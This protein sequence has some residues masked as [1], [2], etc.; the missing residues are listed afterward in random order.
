[1]KKLITFIC[2]NLI[3]KALKI[4]DKYKISILTIVLILIT[5][6]CIFGMSF[7]S[8]YHNNLRKYKEKNYNFTVYNVFTK[9]DSNIYSKLR[10]NE[11]ISDVFFYNEY[12]GLV[13]FDKDSFYLI[14]TIPSN[15]NI[16]KGRNFDV[17]SSNE[18]VCPENF[19]DDM[20]DI[21]NNKMNNIEKYL[22]Q[23]I[24]LHDSNNNEIKMKLVGLF[25]SK[26]GFYEPNEC[27]TS[28]NTVKK[29]NADIND[30]ID[31]GENVNLYI[32]VDDNR[33]L[34]NVKK[35]F[36]NINFDATLTANEDIKNIVCGVILFIMIINLFFEVKLVAKIVSDVKKLNIKKKTLLKCLKIES[37]PLIFGV[38]LGSLFSIFVGN[39]LIFKI[40]PNV[41]LFY[42][43]KIKIKF[44]YIILSLIMVSLSII[45]IDFYSIFYG[46]TKENEEK[47]FV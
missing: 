4:V 47:Q 3:N 41:Y 6:S 28:H 10:E 2:M 1:M 32:Q 14:G 16:T 31:D 21:L 24:I 38:V 25:D 30:N 36:P 15:L 8:F 44:I 33:N 34:D 27:Y 37:K 46:R 45:I 23:E 17:Y 18:I 35:E 9:K 20:N 43:N 40:I 12:K 26:D 19:S 13:K 39:Y 5:T 11:H 29:I 7:F 22:N 42:S